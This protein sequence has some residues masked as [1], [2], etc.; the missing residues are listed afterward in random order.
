[1]V[2]S[3]FETRDVCHNLFPHLVHLSNKVTM[4][5]SQSNDIVRIN[6]HT[7]EICPL[8]NLVYHSFV[9]K[10]C[11][12]WYEHKSSINVWGKH[13]LI[14]SDDLRDQ[15]FHY[16]FHYWMFPYRFH[17]GCQ[18]SYFDLEHKLM[19]M[20]WNPNGD[21]ISLFVRKR[22][23]SSAKKTLWHSS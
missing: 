13:S 5:Q 23:D 14:P 7:S 6:Y 9:L 3:K 2:Y 17:D 1:M 15:M 19:N 8:L 18:C 20:W 4:T 21:L 22:K 11:W 16:Q 10:M 12:I